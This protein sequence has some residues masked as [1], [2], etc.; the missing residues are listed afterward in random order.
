MKENPTDRS[1]VKS[2]KVEVLHSPGFG[3]RLV[4]PALAEQPA[5][6]IIVGSW[7]P[8]AQLDGPPVFELRF[9]PQLLSLQQSS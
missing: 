6:K 8:R 9:R 1:A 7:I 5:R 2:E 4:C 3:Q